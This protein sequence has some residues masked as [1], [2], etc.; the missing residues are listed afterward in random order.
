MSEAFDPYHRWL[1]IPPKEQPPDSYRLLGLTRFEDDRE[2]IEAAA[3]QRMAFLR[4]VQTGP[5]GPLSQ[6]LLNEVAAAKVRLLH[7]EKKA[8]YDRQLREQAAEEHAETPQAVPIVPRAVAVQAGDGADTGPAQAVAVPGEEPVVLPRATFRARRGKRPPGASWLLAPAAAAVALVCV[9]VWLGTGPGV[10]PSDRRTAERMPP[11]QPSVSPPATPPPLPPPPD[12]GTSSVPTESIPAAVA[13]LSDGEPESSDSVPGDP[14]GGQPHFRGGTIDPL[15]DS[16]AE[17]PESGQ[18]P[19]GDSIPDM[20]SPD[21]FDAP[22]FVPPEPSPDARR[23]ADEDAAPVFAFQPGNGPPP[24]A[25]GAASTDDSASPP[26]PRVPVPGAEEQRE[27]QE[28]LRGIHRIDAAK[29]LDEKNTL[30]RRFLNAA[31]AP[32][33]GPAERYVLLR[34]AAQLGTDAAEVD[35]VLEAARRLGRQF[36]VDPLGEELRA[37]EAFGAGAAGSRRAEALV[38]GSAEVIARAV[39]EERFDEARELATLARNACLRP[40]ARE[41]RK[42]AA[43]RLAWVEQVAEQH[44]R[45]A[46]A[47]AALEVNP[48]DPVANDVLSAWYCLV[49]GE[50]ATGL[51]HVARGSD[52]QLRGLARAELAQAAGGG[53]SEPAAEASGDPLARGDAWWDAAAEQTDDA[54]LVALRRA[55]HWYRH[56]DAAALSALRRLQIEKRLEAIAQIEQSLAARRAALRPPPSTSSGGAWRG[57]W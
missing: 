29:T 25:D 6:K 22:V 17:P 52:S 53:N 44:R 50:W 16:P 2:V 40:E 30:A 28:Q 42:E 36:E 21:R 1:G 15:G 55:G 51:G 14:R 4:S 13:S 3:D 32:A 5:R 8:E 27:V 45:L 7:A 12:R 18:S 46:L 39:A 54:R 23:P 33:A 47:R 38:R 9:G 41:W 35:L 48:D 11:V 56:A 37:L 26:P 49:Q 19:G 10:P 20:P 34:L 24:A 31:D 57:G 43:E